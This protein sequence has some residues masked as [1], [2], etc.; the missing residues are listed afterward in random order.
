MSFF[1]DRRRSEGEKGF[2]LIEVLLVLVILVV[3]ASFAVLQFSGIRKKAKIDQAKIQIGLCDSALQNYQISLDAYPTTSQGLSALRKAPAD[4]ADSS[5][6]A[7]PYLQ[8]DVPLDPWGRSYQYACPG[9][10]N[11]DSF[12]V[13]TTGPDGQEIGNW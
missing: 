12:D 11:P 1:H 13:W 5:K 9:N 6:W 10:H 8:S 3:L 2:T 4:L 7:G